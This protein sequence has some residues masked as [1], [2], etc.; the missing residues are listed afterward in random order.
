MTDTETDR[1]ERLKSVYLSVTG[2]TGPVVEPQIEDSHA[3]EIRG[4][5]PTE[6]VG[7]AEH[8]GLADAIDEPDPG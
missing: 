1:T 8:H 5:A 6:A 7:P 3:R 4:E 2:E